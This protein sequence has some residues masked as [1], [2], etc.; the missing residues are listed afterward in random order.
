MKQNAKELGLFIYSQQL[1]DGVR[2]TLSAI[3]PT[4]VFSYFDLFELGITFSIGAV[5]VSIADSP[6]PIIHRKNS[7]LFCIFFLFTTALI[8]LLVRNNFIWMAAEILLAGFFF[9]MFNIYGS[10]AAA[11][12][13]AS[14]L[15][16]ILTMDKPILPEH[17]IRYCLLILMGGFWYFLIS[18]ITYKTRPYRTSQR[19]LGECIRELAQFLSIKARF[20]DCT[21][22]LDE[23]YRKLIAQQIVVSEKQ[24]LVRE[25]LFKTRVTLNETTTA[26]RKLVLAFIDSVDLFEDLTSIYYDYEA[27]RKQFGNTEILTETYHIL[28]QFATELNRIGVAI[29]ANIKYNGTLDFEKSLTDYKSKIDQLSLEQPQIST[30]ALKK[31][32]VNL[33]NISQRFNDLMHYFEA[34]ASVQNRYNSKDFSRFVGHQSLDP[35]LF[36]NNLTFNSSIFRFSL[37]VGIACLVGYF[38][39]KSFVSS[40]HSYWIILTVAFMLKPAFSLTK[41]RNFERIV[42]TISGGIIGALILLLFQ[43]VKVLFAF[44]VVLMIGFY[45]LFRVKYLIS[46]VFL[47]PFI[48]ILLKFMGLPFLSVVQER[49]VDTIIGGVLAFVA[50]YILFP[51]WEREQL[52]NYLYRMLYAN[53][54]YLQKLAQ[55]LTGQNITTTDYKLARKEVY[56]HSAN[57]TAAF[58]RMLSE[59]KSKQK[60]K[61]HIHQFVVLNHILFSN[62]A[63]IAS[64]VIDGNG[65]RYAEDI[66]RP[67]KKALHA[68]CESLFKFDPNC[69]L[70]NIE[71]TNDYEVNS[72]P[73]TDDDLLIKEQM[74]YIHRLSLDISKTTKVIVGE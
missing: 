40:H 64:A 54:A 68:L 30:I 70:P 5:G 50:A 60:N 18:L 59:P 14:L 43:D 24:D 23:D 27:L 11:V 67:A 6:G 2:I 8:T 33:R 31:N 17:I 25:L 1:A 3:V 73:L 51:N 63:T 66:V 47:T 39:A 22:N 36:W 21:T 4:L 72:Q 44:M 29:Y 13:T 10:R 37:R 19:A 32:L 35:K 28:Q 62:I 16:M 61:R 45:S 53:G 71:F 20:Y 57:L 48:I 65:K 55:I 69:S 9:S 74:E 38:I 46:V 7:M 49:I 12:G 15:I 58:Q 56:V 26:S 41:Q 42:G 52:N 34:E